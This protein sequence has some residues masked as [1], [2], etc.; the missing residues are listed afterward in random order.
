MGAVG[1]GLVGD[2][3]FGL[4]GALAGALS[5]GKRTDVNSWRPSRIAAE[6]LLRQI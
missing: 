4:I 2:V 1:W 3:A 6:C 5:G